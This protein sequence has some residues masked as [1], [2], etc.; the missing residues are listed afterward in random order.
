V[1]VAAAAVVVALAGVAAARWRCGGV[2]AGE[3]RRQEIL[4]ATVTAADCRSSGRDGWRTVYWW[5]ERA[6]T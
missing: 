4:E 6:E 2:D 1:V 5:D 3:R